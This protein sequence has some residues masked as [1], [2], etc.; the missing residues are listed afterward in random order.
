MGHT[1]YFMSNHGVH[2]R[3]LW[4]TDGT[5]AGTFMVQD[6]APNTV[7]VFVSAW[8]SLFGRLGG[9]ELDMWHPEPGWLP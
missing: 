4:K 5:E 1:L 6:I 9:R 3:E 7:T 8:E 2:G